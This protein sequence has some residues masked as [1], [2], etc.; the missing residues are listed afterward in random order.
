MAF[1]GDG[2]LSRDEFQKITASVADVPR[3][4]ARSPLL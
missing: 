1:V 3:R 4:G 2:E